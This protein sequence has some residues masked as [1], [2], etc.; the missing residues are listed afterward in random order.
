VDK[1]LIS[2]E[3]GLSLGRVTAA[4]AGWGPFPAK[5][6]APDPVSDQLNRRVTVQITC[7]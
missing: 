4:G 3:T 7:G 5:T 2:P 1:V 6:A